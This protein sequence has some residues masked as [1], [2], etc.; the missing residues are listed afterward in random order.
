MI[1]SRKTSASSLL[2]LTLPT[3]VPLPPSPKNPGIALPSEPS[4]E[5][6]DGGLE[7][8]NESEDEN[9]RFLTPME[10]GLPVSISNETLDRFGEDQN[11]RHLVE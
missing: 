9:D 7:T 4:V 8:P 6:I 10:E 11:I 5:S 1:P 2:T 3:S